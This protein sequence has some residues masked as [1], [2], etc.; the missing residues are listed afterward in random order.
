MNI[1]RRRVLV[2]STGAAAVHALAADAPQAISLAAWSFSGSFFQGKWKLL[3]LPGI[4]RD[5]LRISALEHVNQF[6]EN[7]TLTYLQRLKKSC[8]DA[9]VRSTILMV[10]NEGATAAQDKAERHLAAVAHRK[11]ID[12]A[13]YLGCISVRCN[14]YGGAED[15]KQDKDLV[16]RA[17]E[18][19]HSMLDYAKG[20]GLNIIVENHGRASSDP[21]VLVALVKKVDHPQF[22]L[23]C[24]LGNWN[25][26]ADRYANSKKV[27][28]Y[29]KGLS[30]KGTWGE[31]LDPGFDCE[32]LVKVAYDGGYKG[33]WGL[34]VTPRRAQDAPKL[35]AEEQFESE[36][37]TILE[38]KAIVERVVLRKA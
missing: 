1:T 10:D 19:L 4:I 23:L 9:G 12:V 37:R 8:S 22:G 30:V 14:V 25:H 5:R 26:G 27:L 2:S 21:D 33:Y 35:S 15:W 38:A 32:K 6:F 36:V 24:D 13:H 3:E 16:D 11:W 31:G 7:P 20:S 29:A 34:E 28:P 18:S 17:A